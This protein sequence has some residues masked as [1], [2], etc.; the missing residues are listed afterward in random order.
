MGWFAS[1]DVDNA[2]ALLRIDPALLLAQT[3]REMP[4]A[5]VRALELV[6]LFLGHIRR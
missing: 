3:A 1:G 6:D 4:L 2:L 5:R